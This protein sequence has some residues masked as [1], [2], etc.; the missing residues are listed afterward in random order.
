MNPV[1]TTSPWE[2][3]LFYLIVCAG[4]VFACLWYVRAQDT[5]SEMAPP[6]VPDTVDPYEI[7][8]MRGGENELVRVVIVGLAERGYVEAA[9]TAIM[10]TAKQPAGLAAL[11]QTVYDALANGATAE[12]IFAGGLPARVKALCLPYD[13]RL[14]RE[15]L[16]RADTGDEI[17]WPAL[18][19]GLSVIGGLLAWRLASVSGQQPNGF[20]YAIGWGSFCSL[21]SVCRVARL[22]A[23][24]TRYLERLK[25][26]RSSLRWSAGTSFALAAAVAGMA[27]LSE[28]SQARL[29]TLFKKSSASGGGCGDGCG[30]CGGCG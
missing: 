27:A 21:V 11:E 7:A 20:L 23:R 6:A 15:Q 19:A 8:Y 9:D 17:E 22:T 25:E 4:T 1:T 16:V 24:G 26:R 28:T 29:G 3:L 10:T 5:T 2:F 30:G 14:Q 12:A 13:E 18:L